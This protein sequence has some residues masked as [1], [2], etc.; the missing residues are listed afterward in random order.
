M[1]LFFLIFVLLLMIALIV[2]FAFPP[3]RWAERVT[4][5]P[6][7]KGAQVAP[8][9]VLQSAGTCDGDQTG[10]RAGAGCG[11]RWHML[12]LQIR[13]EVQQARRVH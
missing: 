2:L 3:H 7:K 5:D 6:T 8:Q 1:A 10:P 11:S 13:R 12:S 4:K 9:R